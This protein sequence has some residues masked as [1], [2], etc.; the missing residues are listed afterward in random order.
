MIFTILEALQ[1]HFLFSTVNPGKFDNAYHLAKGG[2]IHVYLCRD[3]LHLDIIN[4][5]M[6]F[7]LE[8]MRDWDTFKL[9]GVLGDFVGWLPEIEASRQ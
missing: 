8:D 3:H 6:H 2:T 5:K 1:V 9:T 7:T 4:R